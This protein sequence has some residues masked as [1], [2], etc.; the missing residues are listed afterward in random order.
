MEDIYEK[1][2]ALLTNAELSALWTY[3]QE[4]EI[5]AAD[6]GDYTEA[7]YHKRRK[8]MFYRQPNTPP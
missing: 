3:H 4:A 8:I 7:E 2:K 5:K 1:A 6:K